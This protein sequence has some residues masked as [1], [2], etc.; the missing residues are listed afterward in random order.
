MFNSAEYQDQDPR[1]A[2]AFRKEEI[3]ELHILG[4]IDRKTEQVWNLA[5]TGDKTAK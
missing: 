3:M 2:V 4:G 1:V 5:E